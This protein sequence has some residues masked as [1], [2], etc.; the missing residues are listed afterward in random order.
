MDILCV[1]G[2]SKRQ[3]HEL[4]LDG[5]SFTEQKLEKLAMVGETGSGKT[6]LLKIIA[7]LVQAD[8][9]EVRFEGEKVKGPDEKLIPGH[10]GIAYLSQHF[11]LHNNYRVEELLRYANELPGKEAET[12]YSICRIDHLLQRR[13]D[14]LSGGE[15][16]RIAL[17]RLLS[18]RPRLLL[19]DEPF[20]NLDMIHKR[21]IK[22]VIS[23]IS[24]QLKISC[25]LVAHEPTDILSWA[26][27]ILVIKGGKL[28]QQGPPEEVYRQP[29]NEYTAALL[30]N[31]NIID[32]SVFKTFSALPGDRFNG[33]K[34]LVRPEHFKLATEAQGM[35]KGKVSKIDF[36]GSHYEIEVLALENTIQVKTENNNLSKGDTVYLCV[37]P[38]DVWYV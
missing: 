17:A 5:I 2:I 14:Q 20:S 27:K 6:T 3:G 36:F 9:G 19:V 15:R 38:D 16:Q 8:A 21:I 22:S 29:V 26:D 7:G 12:I 11:E 4:I 31:Y 10:I 34:I 35:F 23:D 32:A 28:L 33:K 30:G 1:N 25:L 37:A 24:D 18:S 13:T